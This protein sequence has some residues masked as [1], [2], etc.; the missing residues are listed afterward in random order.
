VSTRPTIIAPMKAP[1]I[2]PMP[3]I[4]MTTKVEDQDLLAHADLHRRDGPGHQ[5]ASPAISA[6]SPKTEV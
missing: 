5:P 4:T 6:P 2:E 1:R 3:P